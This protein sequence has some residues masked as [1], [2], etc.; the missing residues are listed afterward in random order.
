M[1]RLQLIHVCGGWQWDKATCIP[2]QTSTNPANGREDGGN[3][4]PAIAETKY[5][6]SS[7]GSQQQLQIREA[8]YTKAI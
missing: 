2:I 1:N 3:I 7:V 8:K 4:L 6:T 5:R